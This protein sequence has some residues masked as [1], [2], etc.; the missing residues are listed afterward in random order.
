MQ[1]PQT[2]DPES[3]TLMG[4][5]CYDAWWE[6]K[7][8]KSY[9]SAGAEHAIRNLLA[10]RVMEAVGRGERDPA[11]L[12]EIALRDGAEPVE[13]AGRSGSDISRPRAGAK[14]RA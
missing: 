13:V 1:L 6:L 14:A 3:V 2:F 4:R 11:L 12:R 8:S 10:L 5:V 7:S 9:P